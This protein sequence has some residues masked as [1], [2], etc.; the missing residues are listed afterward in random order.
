M[1][2]N[3]I[4]TAE[5]IVNKYKERDPFRLCRNMD[6]I[7]LFQPLGKEKG[8]IK[9]FYFESH[10]IRTITVNSDLSEELQRIITAH[11]LGHALLHCT[12]ET[13]TFH[14]TGFF[15]DHLQTEKEAN[16]FAAELLLSDKEVLDALNEKD[17]FFSAAASLKIP[18]QL[19]D[20]KLRVMRQKGYKISPTPITSGN[21]FLSEITNE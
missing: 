16:L 21:G 12:D 5:N 6:I 4:E 2:K 15:D 10:R 19:L 18:C 1:Y 17:S 11:E 20:F 3:I 7:I 13:R 8:A 9:G 14:E